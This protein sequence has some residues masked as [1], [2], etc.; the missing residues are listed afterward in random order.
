[1]RFST[2]HWAGRAEVRHLGALRFAEVWFG[3]VGFAEVRNSS[4]KFA[5]V[6]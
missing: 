1:M 4:L 5:A 3:S 6:R 2:V